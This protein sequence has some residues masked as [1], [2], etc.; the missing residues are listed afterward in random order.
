[1]RNIDYLAMPT[2]NKSLQLTA[3][4]RNDQLYFMKDFLILAKLGAASDS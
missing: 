4:W 1:L 3:G 2:P